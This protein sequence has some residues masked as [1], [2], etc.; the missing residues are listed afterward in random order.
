MS[1]HPKYCGTMKK[2]YFSA[3]VWILLNRIIVWVP[4]IPHF[5]G[6]GMLNFQYEIR[7]CKNI[8]NKVTMWML[9]QFFFFFLHQTLKSVNSNFTLA[10][11]SPEF[12]HAKTHLLSHFEEK[13]RKIM[14][15]PGFEPMIS[16]WEVH[17]ANNY[18]MG[19]LLEIY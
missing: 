10:V 7:M 2:S 9:W 1:Q 12:N 15:R 13:K 6:L 8:H 18:S 19:H 3:F 17:R 5:K 16:R 11:H 14:A 4:S